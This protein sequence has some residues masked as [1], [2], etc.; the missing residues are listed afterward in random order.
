[1]TD[2]TG[3]LLVLVTLMFTFLTLHKDHPLWAGIVYILI[4][5]MTYL[6][7]SASNAYGVIIIAIGFIRIFTAP[8]G[9]RH[10]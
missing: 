2:Y 5:G 1:M 7:M 3:V 6:V 8:Y 10:D 4:G 9:E